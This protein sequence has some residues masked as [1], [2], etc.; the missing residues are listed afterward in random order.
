MSLINIIE[1]MMY[2]PGRGHRRV[3]VGTNIPVAPLT[4]VVVS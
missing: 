3:S 2:R 1:S 4:N